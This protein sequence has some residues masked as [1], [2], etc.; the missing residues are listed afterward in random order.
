MTKIVVDRDLCEANARCVA[1][2]PEVFH[3]DENDELHLATETVDEELRSK[4]EA[5]VRVCPRQALSLVE[6]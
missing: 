2:C 6:E 4:I 5:A 3:V 1:V